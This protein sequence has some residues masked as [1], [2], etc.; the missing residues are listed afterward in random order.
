MSFP[1]CIDTTIR[2]SFV[3]CPTQAK[4]A[5]FENL[6]P[7]ATSVDLLFGGALAHGL[8]TARRW[9][10]DMKEASAQSIQA[11]RIAAEQYY[12]DFDPPAKSSKTKLALGRALEYYFTVWP[13]G[14]D[15]LQPAR[16]KDGKLM[17]E[18]RFKLPIPGLVHPDHGGPIYLVGRSDMIPMLQGFLCIEDDKSASQ[19]GDQWANKWRMDAQPLT[20]IYAGQQ[21]GLLD[22]N[23]DGTAIFRGLSILQPKYRRPGSTGKPTTRKESELQDGEWEFVPSA[24]F[25]TSQVLI[26]HAP[27]RIERWLKQF[28]AD[29]QRMVYAYLNNE[30]GYALHR[31]VCGAY[32]GCPYLLLCEVQDP[33]TGGWK[34]VNFVK[35]VWN[36]LD[37]I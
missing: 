31:D 34:E 9:F 6:A 5:Y 4:Y 30:W 8:E 10:Y 17:V 23:T 24:S 11:G 33:D 3:L 12:G 13:L 22:P 21:C 15:I 2:N 27:W 32:N 19:L 16:D 36:P 37:T 18:W 35:R 25:G 28:T 20:Y 26:T 14:T 7:S 1:D 29:I